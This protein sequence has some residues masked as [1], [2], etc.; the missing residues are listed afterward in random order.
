MKKAN[1][2]IV[3]F[4]FITM[5]MMEASYLGKWNILGACMLI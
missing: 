5:N 2:I 1:Y 4:Y 3:L